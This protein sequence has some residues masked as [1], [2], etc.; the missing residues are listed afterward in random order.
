M[1][2][3]GGLDER[4][5]IVE[6]TYDGRRGKLCDVGITIDDVAVLCRMLGYQA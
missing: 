4:E 5:G 3:V 6:L 2:L 1:T